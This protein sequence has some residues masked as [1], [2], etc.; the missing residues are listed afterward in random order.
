MTDA[1]LRNSVY[2]L[3]AKLCAAR[4]LYEENQREGVRAAV[5][6]LSIFVTKISYHGGIPHLSSARL[7]DMLG[8]PSLALAGLDQGSVDPLLAHNEERRRQ[9]LLTFTEVA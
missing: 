5:A 8:H 9:M 7:D 2:L 3:M 4:A 6:S 1:E